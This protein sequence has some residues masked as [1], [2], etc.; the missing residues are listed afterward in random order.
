MEHAELRGSQQHPVNLG[1]H[2]LRVGNDE[3]GEIPVDRV[4]ASTVRGRST[5]RRAASQVERSGGEHLL[6]AVAK[7][8]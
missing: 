2:V 8:M 5:T 3:G 7:V 4:E 1:D 6:Q